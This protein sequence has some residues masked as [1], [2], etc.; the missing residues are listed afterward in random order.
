MA[1]LLDTP[2]RTDSTSDHAAARL[3]WRRFASGRYLTLT[4]AA[5]VV[6]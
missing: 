1:V 2:P 4:V 6:A 3:G 5:L